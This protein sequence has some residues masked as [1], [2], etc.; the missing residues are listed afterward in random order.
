MRKPVYRVLGWDPVRF[1]WT[2]RST[3]DDEVEAAEHAEA[4]QH[5]NPRLR[6]MITPATTKLLTVKPQVDSEFRNW[7]LKVAGQMSDLADA[8]KRYKSPG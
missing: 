8:K 3:H 4:M 2:V 1:V 6:V 5:R 7:R